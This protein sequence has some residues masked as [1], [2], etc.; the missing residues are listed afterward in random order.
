MK[1][2]TI[3]NQLGNNFILVRLQSKVTTQ[4]HSFQQDCTKHM[5]FKLKFNLLPKLRP[6]L[7]KHSIQEL[8]KRFS[9]TNVF[10]ARVKL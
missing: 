6:I 5:F 2:K 8:L 10:L 7:V 1:K 9:K 4:S 3:L